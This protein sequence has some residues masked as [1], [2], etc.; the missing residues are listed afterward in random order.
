MKKFVFGLFAF[1]LMLSCSEPT[2]KGETISENN[3]LPAFDSL[4][5]EKH[6]YAANDSS[7]PFMKLTLHFIYPVAYTNDSA[8]IRI[9]RLFAE[10]FAGK[11]YAGRSPKG[12]FE[13]LDK[14]I[15]DDALAL[16]SELRDDL[17]DFAEYYWTVKTIVSGSFGNILTVQ[18]TEETYTGGAHGSYRISFYNIDL[19]ENKLLTED[20]LFKAGST[21]QLTALIMEAL[22]NEYGDKLDNMLFD[23][24][25]VRPNGNFYINKDKIVYVYNQYEIAPYAVGVIEAPIP[26]EKAKELMMLEIE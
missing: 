26:M 23:K 17:N 15:S 1:F 7:K 6:I 13:A 3:D 25:D 9:Q 19:K 11:E 2:K 22:Q 18:T 16:A 8:L 12:A 14:K 5:V 10:A 4:A 20:N 24:N 21:A